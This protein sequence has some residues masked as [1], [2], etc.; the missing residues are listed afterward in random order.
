VGHKA[1]EFLVEVAAGIR[2]ETF[3]V[4]CAIDLPCGAEALAGRPADD[5]VDIR[6]AD[7]GLKFQGGERREILFEHMANVLEI[8]LED[9]DGLGIGVDGGEAVEAGALEAEGEA[10][11]AAEQVDEGERRFHGG[12]AD[13]GG[14][15]A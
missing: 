12:E 9:L 8:G 2:L 7:H 6:G 11:A 4:V 15:E 13:Y 10:A 1:Q 14:M 3:A 5:Q